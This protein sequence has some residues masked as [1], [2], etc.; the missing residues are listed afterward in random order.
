[1]T[2]GEIVAARPRLLADKPRHMLVAEVIRAHG[3]EGA[4]QARLLA[5]SWEGL[6]RPGTLYLEPAPGGERSGAPATPLPVECVG[7]AGTRLILKLAGVETREQ[8][9]ALAGRQLTMPRSAAPPLPEGQYYHY[10][11]LGLTVVDG[12]GRDLGQVV[13][14]VP[15]PANDVYVVRGPRGEW[16]LPAIRAVI[17]AV[18]L[19]AGALRVRD[20]T[21]LL[22]G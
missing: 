7:G 11:F 4:V 17:A 21:G 16:L 19:E 18:D 20:V 1:M 14:I 3:L 8:A 9:A 10:D 6:G 15:T 13:E 2:L 12:D 22:E 5:D